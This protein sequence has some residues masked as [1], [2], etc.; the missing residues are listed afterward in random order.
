MNRIKRNSLF[1]KF[2]ITRVEKKKYLLLKET[3]FGIL[4]RCKELENIRL[5]NGDSFLVKL[6]KTQLEEDWRTPLLKALKRT[7]KKHRRPL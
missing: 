7:L 1:K 5:T 4:A 3:D 2:G 6:I